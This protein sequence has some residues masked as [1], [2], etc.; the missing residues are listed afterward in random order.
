MHPLAFV[1]CILIV[2]ISSAQA[3]FV[4]GNEL[5]DLCASYEA[6]TTDPA[7]SETA[8]FREASC[9]YYIIRSADA[10]NYCPPEGVTSENI[11]HIVIQYMDQHPSEGHLDAAQLI[12]RALTEQFPCP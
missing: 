7:R 6:N 9:V 2:S 5:S 3:G 1:L 4:D 12:Q 8:L 10:T 11:I